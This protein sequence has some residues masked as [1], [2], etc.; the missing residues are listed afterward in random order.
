MVMLKYVEMAVRI[1]KS[2]NEEANSRLGSRNAC[3]SS[4]QSLL[5]FCILRT[6]ILKYTEITSYTLF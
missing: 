3:C 1:N 5:P 2:T 6:Q 4:V